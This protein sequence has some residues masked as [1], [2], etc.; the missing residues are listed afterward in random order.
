MLGGWFLILPSKAILLVSV[1]PHPGISVKG[2]AI[3]V[4][5]SESP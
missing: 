5:G 3:P 4:T 1:T 2:K